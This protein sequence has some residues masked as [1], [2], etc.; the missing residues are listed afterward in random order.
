M[1]ATVPEGLPDG[2]VIDPVC[3]M[4]VHLGPHAITLQHDGRT[5]GFCATGCREVYAAD[6]CISS[7]DS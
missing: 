5:I 4:R 3:G 6:H 7:S 1:C 2:G